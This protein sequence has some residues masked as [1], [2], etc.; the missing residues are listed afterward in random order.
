[1][2]QILLILTLLLCFATSALAVEPLQVKGTTDTGADDA[3]HA[4]TFD[5]SVVVGSTIIVNSCSWKGSDSSVTISSVSDPSN[6]AYTQ[7]FITPRIQDAVT[8]VQY[9]KNNV[10]TGGTLTIT[11]TWN[12]TVSENT[13][14]IMEYSSAA[15]KVSPTVTTT[16]GSCVTSCTTSVTSGTI[17]PSA[18]SIYVAMF[19]Y[20]NGTGPISDTVAGGFIKQLEV[21]ENNANQDCIVADQQN[22]S[23][24]QQATWTM[25][26]AG[27]WTSGIA[28]YESPAAAGGN[29]NY[30]LLLLGIGAQL[31]NFFFPG[32]AFN[33]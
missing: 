15:I 6:G 30:R 8:C 19:G 21:D 9:Y 31:M 4:V 14:A 33:A 29:T 3:S 20:N 17:A 11:V 23:G 28:S 12:K 27:T 32:S 25:N 26:T 10:T 16:T 2:R 18:T 22:V 5:N 7:A 24:S 1:M 13:V